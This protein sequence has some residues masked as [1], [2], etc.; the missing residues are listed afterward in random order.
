MRH[1]W[2]SEERAARELTHRPEAK[3][4]VVRAELTSSAYGRL[5]T[6]SDDVRHRLNPIDGRDAVLSPFLHIVIG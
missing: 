4:A 2:N 6:R 5:I 1:L 3:G